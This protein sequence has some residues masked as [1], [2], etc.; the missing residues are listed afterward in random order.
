M[1]CR[2]ASTYNGVSGSGQSGGGGYATEAEC[3]QACKEGACC[4]GATCSVK[5]QCQCQCTTG[6]CCGPDTTTAGGTTWKTCRN[7]SKAACDARGGVYQ[8]G[9]T[10]TT[11]VIGDAAGSTGG[12]VCLNGTGDVANAGP[13]FKGVGTVCTPNPCLCYCGDGS[14]LSAL[15]LSATI[16]GTTANIGTGVY[17]RGWPDLTNKT[18]TYTLSKESCFRWTAT[19]PT[20]PAMLEGS[21]FSATS[22]LVFTTGP[23]S[24]TRFEIVVL[25]NVSGE[26]LA[27]YSIW[28]RFEADADSR[29]CHGESIT[30]DLSEGLS[31][32]DVVS[33]Q[34]ITSNPLP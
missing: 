34:A 28:Q 31:N 6:R 13:V 21:T 24:S 11:G 10:C 18:K 27:T 19:I 3:L 4:E 30:S 29:F 2:Q 20:P 14:T 5:P 16:T 22:Q 8:C 12:S 17:Y 26:N 33:I 15:A 32:D 9:A 7:E 1:P 25:H 23:Q